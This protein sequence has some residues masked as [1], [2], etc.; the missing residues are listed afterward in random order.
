MKVQ[1]T[2]IWIMNETCRRECSDLPSLVLSS[3]PKSGKE[4][5]EKCRRKSITAI[6]V[7]DDQ[8]PPLKSLL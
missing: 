6:R 4:L 8:S 7:S 1:K 3:I 2:C 5:K